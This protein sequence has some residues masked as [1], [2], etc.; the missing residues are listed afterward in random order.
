MLYHNDNLADTP[1]KDRSEKVQYCASVML[2]QVAEVGY[3]PDKYLIVFVGSRESTSIRVG[4]FEYFGHISQ[5]YRA[6][7]QATRDE[8]R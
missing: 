2:A 8:K 7:I 3:T 6:L 5:F 4:T 1:L